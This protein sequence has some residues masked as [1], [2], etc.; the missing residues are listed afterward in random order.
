MTEAKSHTEREI[1]HVGSR[2]G[3]KGL[4]ISLSDSEI[5]NGQKGRARSFEVKNGYFQKAFFYV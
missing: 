3:S 4:K 2:L 5:L 1:D